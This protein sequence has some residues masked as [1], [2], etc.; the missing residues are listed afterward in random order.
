MEWRTIPSAPNYEASESGEIRNRTTGTI[1]KPQND[2][3]AGYHK[4]GVRGEDGSFSS[5]YV[6]HLV[7]EAFFGKRADRSDVDHK[8]GCKTNNA[9]VNLH[10]CTRRENQ[11]NPNNNGMNAWQKYASRGVIAIKDGVET[12]FA[13]MSEAANRLGLCLS[14]ISNVLSGKL[15]NKGY[16]N[17]RVRCC[18][19]STC[20]GYS[21]RWAEASE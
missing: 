2:R 19:I 4:V 7:A 8:D 10:Y 20:G 21:F 13:N 12:A 3:R 9:V 18:T 5:R 11:D 15:V 1:L 16:R 14:G 17:G 6:H